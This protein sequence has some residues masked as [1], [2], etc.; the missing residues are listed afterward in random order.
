MELIIVD[1]DK[2][3][4]ECEGRKFTVKESLSFARYKVLQE[5][6]LEFGYSANF[7]ETFKQLRIAWDHLN[8]LRLGEAAVTLHNVMYGVVSLD[9]KHDPALR[10]CALFIDEE[11]EDPAVY[12]EGK[13][14]EKIDCWERGRLDVSPF[15]QLAANLCPDW[16]PA[17]KLVTQSISKEKGSDKEG[18]SQ[19]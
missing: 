12:D 4:F 5:L 1:L 2:K 17:Y 15:F 9:E 16:I 19:S 11:G 10:M 18:Q 14:R 7:H 3:Y 8:N 6:N 13:M